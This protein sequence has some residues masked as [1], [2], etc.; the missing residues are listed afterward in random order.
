MRRTLPFFVLGII[1]L[2]LVSVTGAAQ[3]VPEAEV[4][5]SPPP[6]LKTVPVPEPRELGEFVRDKSAAIA[7]GKALFWDQQVGGDGI[8]ACATCHFQAGADGRPVNQLNAG[9]DGRF[10]TGGPN[11]RFEPGD[12]P[13]HQLADPDDRRSAVLRSRD[14]VG[15]SQGVHASEFT[16]VQLF[17]SRDDQV[18]GLPDP[19]GFAVGG[20]N[21]R[22]VTGRNTPPAIN[23]VF[24]VRNFWD[25]RASRRFNGRNPFGDSDPSARV[26][27]VDD[28][29]EIEAV[30]ISIDRASLASQA[31]GPPLSDVEMSAS[32]RTWLKL[33]K[34]MLSLPP[35]A[36]QRVHPDD[37]VLGPLAV[38]GGRGLHTTY[39][40]LVRQAFD[41]RWWDSNVVVDGA[42]N[43]LPGEFAPADG[44]PLPTDRYTLMEANFPLFWGLAIQCYEATLVSDDA[45]YDRFAEGA[46]HALTGQQ[47]WGLELFLSSEGGNCSGCHAGPE[48]TGATFS[49]RLD[50]TTPDGMIEHMIMGDGEPAFYDG[51]FYNI[52]VRPTGDDIGLGANDPFGNPLSLA[53]R[54]QR[55][56]GSVQDHFAGPIGPGDRIAADGAFKTPSLRNV[57]LTG[58]YFHDGSVASL[59]DVVRFYT[60]GGNFHD[61][62]MAD[63]DPDIHRQRSLVGR[64]ARQM[65]IVAFLR[66][67]TDERVRWFRAPFDHPELSLPNGA[68]G[69]EW[70][71]LADPAIAGQA[72]DAVLHLPATGRSGA[73]E[74]LRPFLGI[75]ALPHAAVPVPDPSQSTLALFATDTLSVNARGESEGDLWSNGVLRLHGHRGTRFKGDLASGGD[76][77]LGG[78]SLV[79]EGSVITRGNLSR[80]PGVV[81]A[82]GFTDEHVETFAP[83]AP[84]ELPDAALVAAPTEE[85]TSEDAME[86]GASRI[87]VGEGETRALPPGVYGALRAQRGST[88][89]LGEGDYTFGSIALGPDAWLRY[90]EDG[91]LDVALGAGEDELPSGPLER[92][93]V[94]VLGELRL[95]A[96]ATVSSGSEDRSMRL[97]LYVH[98]PN[99]TIVLAARTLLHA[100]LIAPGARV[101]MAAGSALHGA[102][103]AR[104][105]EVAEG[106]VFEPHFRASRPTLVREWQPPV[107]LKAEGAPSAAGRSTASVAD[108]AFALQPNEPNPFRPSTR[109]RF[110]LPESRD[111]SL[112]IYDVAGRSV[113]TLTDA[114]LEPGLH[115]L[116]WDGT[117][118]AGMRLPAGVYL[119]RL[120]AGRDRA[121]RKL[122]MVE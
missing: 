12:F 57:E 60:R 45:P 55:E 20:L 98:R 63:L 35:L 90:D 104:T 10:E 87:V 114:R 25:G 85:G 122:V 69:S 34:K 58:P 13:F 61:E 117:S 29:G 17:T 39:A 52:G 7:L 41:P 112:V 66:S 93:I 48:F 107:G 82:G 14:D 59:A 70:S 6:S 78:D 80:A 74:P 24:N 76:L 50:P 91:V 77:R 19:L 28:L 8:V 54:E 31:V 119:Y 75:P 116:E 111:V 9:A 49:A 96:G 46:S 37:S 5:P 118:D 22:R 26:L 89:I 56:P 64:P 44:T 36:L 88:V 51:G 108:L 97:R 100:S 94:H 109:I 84:L 110:A 67:L 120:V 65:A 23:A 101:H 86:A 27:R 62:N 32:G 33:G 99:Q 16:D 38:V 11:H 21:V 4:A 18:A 1:V 102:I 113:R 92:T 40:D 53:R 2:E 95:A 15:G 103:H 47:R 81:L 68:P 121:E 106:A 43:V 71:V 73:S 3:I 115:T 83:L 30:R 42:L 79:I 72:A 105:I